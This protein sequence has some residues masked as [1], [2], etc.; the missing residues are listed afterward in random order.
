[1]K[2]GGKGGVP[3]GKSKNNE[4][5]DSGEKRR[6]KGLHIVASEGG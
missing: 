3:G 2:E 5:F 6:K 4:G 1:M